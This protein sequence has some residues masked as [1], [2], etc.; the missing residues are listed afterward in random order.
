M[1]RNWIF[2][3]LVE[4]LIIFLVVNFYKH[5]IRY[6]D[7][8]R[9]SSRTASDPDQEWRRTS[10][11]RTLPDRLQNLDQRDPELVE[12]IRRHWIEPPSAGRLHLDPKV[13]ITR[14]PDFTEQGQ[15]D[16]VLELLHNRRDGFF[17]ECGAADGQLKSNSLYLELFMNWTGLLIEADRRLFDKIRTKS[18]H[19]YLVN[20][21]LSPVAH[22]AIMNFTAIRDAG[23]LNELISEGQ[24]DRY[25]IDAK[26]STPIQCLPLYSILSAIGV[27][28]VDYFSLDVEGAEI[29]VLKTIPFDE[30]RIDVVSVEKRIIGDKVGTDEK[31]EA[32][33]SLLSGYGYNL[34]N[35]M[36]LDIMLARKDV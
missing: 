8:K 36:R 14:H 15:V 12:H 28:H 11:P 34:T 6:S 9:I 26:V 23:G 5:E 27:S 29:D 2:W 32:V 24:K 33:V 17:V 1:V 21:C 3:L 18:R 13:S 7:D 22:S 25:N 30:V 31:E 10:D 19:A 16:A 4:I 20:A 35:K